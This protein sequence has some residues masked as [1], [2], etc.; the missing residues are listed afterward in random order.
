MAKCKCGVEM[1]DHKS[2]K[3]KF[4]QKEDGTK[5]ARIKCGDE[6]R[7]LEGCGDCAVKKG[8]YHHIG[9]DMEECPVCHRQLLSCDCNFP[10][11]SR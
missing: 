5:I 9:C 10:Y 7:E 11:W 3:F 8:Q 4:V 2:C 1:L 6:E